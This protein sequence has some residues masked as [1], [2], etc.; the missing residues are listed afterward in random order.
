MHT[1]L[2]SEWYEPFCDILVKFLWISNVC[3]FRVDNLRC[4]FA[5]VVNQAQGVGV[6]LVICQWN[7]IEDIRLYFTLIEIQVRQFAKL[8][9]GETHRYSTVVINTRIHEVGWEESCS[10]WYGIFYLQIHL[11]GPWRGEARDKLVFIGCLVKIYIRLRVLCLHSVEWLQW[12]VAAR[13]FVQCDFYTSH[14]SSCAEW[15]SSAYYS[16]CQGKSVGWFADKI[17]FFF[18]AIS[19]AR[20]LVFIISPCLCSDIIISIVIWCAWNIV[21]FSEIILTSQQSA[22]KYEFR[23]CIVNLY[24]IPG[25]FNQSFVCS[26]AC[27]EPRYCG[28]TVDTTC[29]NIR[30][31]RVIVLRND[32]GLVF[33]GCAG[34]SNF[35]I[36]IFNISCFIIDWYCF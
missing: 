20:H 10:L 31:K 7:V 6:V 32:G 17:L 29:C 22:L 16:S 28:S 8:T 1:I 27:R 15:Y 35:F 36:S 25:Q 11:H 18:T 30:F 13:A 12:Q 3:R 4:H 23:W 2:V 34:I 19:F 24:Y 21:D 14:G 26:T 33:I 9:F 5:F